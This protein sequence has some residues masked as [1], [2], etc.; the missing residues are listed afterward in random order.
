MKNSEKKFWKGLSFQKIFE[1]NT[2][3]L[4]FSI[5]VGIVVW[6]SI[7]NDQKP[8]SN[9]IIND[10][11]VTINY[12][13]SMARD[14]G[15][16]IIGETQFY[17]DVTVNGKKYTV[18]HLTADDF[19]AQ[20]SL[21]SVTK[22]GDYT[23]QVQVIRNESSP[24]YTIVS[25]TEPEITLTFD[26]VVSKE[27]SLEIDKSGLTVA[28]GYILETP[29]ADYDAITVKGPQ[30]EINKIA[31]CAVSAVADDELDKT[32][33]VQSLVTLLDVEGNLIESPNITLEASVVEVT[34][35]VYKTKTVPLEVEFINIPKGFS[36]ESLN[37]TMTRTS[38]L[39]ASPNETVDNIESVSLG[40]VDFRNVDIGSEISLEVVLNAG[41]KNVENISEVTITFPT[42]GYSAGT[43]TLSN[44]ITENLPS[45]YEVNILGGSL[46]GVKVVGRNDVMDDLTAE[47]L[48]GS[49]D[50]SQI[51]V[52]KGNYS[53]TVNVY[54][55]G[56]KLAWAVGSYQV[57]IEIKD[58][59]G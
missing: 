9:Y 17:V 50:L 37:Y 15:L 48:V 47:D 26:K 41:L 58:K 14:L 56:G 24:D 25:W 52:A 3:V 28:D 21:S 59:R 23:L 30:T 31:K 43:F 53:V 2:F 35:P 46:S 40:P 7:Y 38:I 18:T 32:F 13:N 55:Q 45:G 10:V 27:F 57:N 12:E 49:V 11:P 4:V 33:T 1:N 20:V 29:Y 6:F 8:N 5:L 36:I 16:E 39:I 51:T 19:S 22:A 44:F 34:V 42:V 54:C